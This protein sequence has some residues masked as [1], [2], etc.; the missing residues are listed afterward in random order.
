MVFH[1][2]SS[3]FSAS[4]EWNYI[5]ETSVLKL[6]KFA[7]QRLLHFICLYSPESKFVSVS[8]WKFYNTAMLFHMIAV[9]LTG[10]LPLALE[11]GRFDGPPEENFGVWPAWYWVW[12][13]FCLPLMTRGKYFSQKCCQFIPIFFW[14]DEYG[15]NLCF[16]KGTLFFVAD[17]RTQAGKS[18]QNLMFKTRRSKI[19][20]RYCNK[21]KCNG[22]FEC[23]SRNFGV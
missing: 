18:L 11:T 9:R 10:A 5:N 14:L 21:I 17:F 12:A 4:C 7:Y 16:R 2:K 20:C 19:S 3:S 23:C 6:T 8:F 22:L 13:S 1:K 15:Y